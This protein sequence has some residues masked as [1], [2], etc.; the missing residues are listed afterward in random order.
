MKSITPG[1]SVLPK[2]KQDI[3]KG[4]VG[5]VGTPPKTAGLSVFGSGKGK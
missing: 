3:G 4:S 1:Q 5:S 2:P